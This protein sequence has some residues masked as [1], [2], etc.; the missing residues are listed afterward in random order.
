MRG[1]AAPT[2][3]GLSDRRRT[4]ARVGHLIPR[5]QVEIERAVRLLRFHFIDRR[6][7]A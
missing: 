1:A 2:L 6:V 5:K 4:M 7:R 3:A